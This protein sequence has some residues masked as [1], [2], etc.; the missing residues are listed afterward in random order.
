MNKENQKCTWDPGCTE[1]KD[2]SHECNIGIDIDLESKSQPNCKYCYD[3]KYFTVAEG[4]NIVRGDF[5]GDESWYNPLTIRKIDCRCV[6]KYLELSEKCECRCHE[7][8]GHSPISIWCTCPINS[9][10]HCM[11][12][13][14]E[15][16]NKDDPDFW[17]NQIIKLIKNLLESQKQQIYEDL[18]GMIENDFIFTDYWAKNEAINKIEK[19]FNQPQND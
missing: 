11:F 16:K 6:K 13:T 5:V 17:R 12:E 19:Y 15:Y 8:C 3:K 14:S 4:G 10:N 7:G 1:T 2:H 18:K 9:C